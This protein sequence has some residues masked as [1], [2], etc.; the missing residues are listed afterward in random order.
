MDV[1]S[2]RTNRLEWAPRLPIERRAWFDLDG[3]GKVE[4][5]GVIY[6]GD[7]YLLGRDDTRPRTRPA[8]PPRIARSEQPDS[9]N[10]V[11]TYL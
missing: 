3:D 11:D 4:D 1:S 7:G 9:A 5:A 6:G 2:I 10:R 8:P